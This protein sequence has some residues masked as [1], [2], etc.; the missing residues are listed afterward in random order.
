MPKHLKSSLVADDDD[1]QT[2]SELEAY[3]ERARARR[4]RAAVIRA[5]KEDMKE[6]RSMPRVS[7]PTTYEIGDIPCIVQP[8]DEDRNVKVALNTTGDGEVDAVLHLDKK[9][10][11]TEWITGSAYS[12]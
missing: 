9:K 2:R 3:Q 8:A 1:V 11:Q 10:E 12:R 4:E 5:V 6:R 7:E